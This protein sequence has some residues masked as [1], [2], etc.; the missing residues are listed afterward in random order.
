MLQLKAWNLSLSR[1]QMV[2]IACWNMVVWDVVLAIQ[3]F[4]IDERIRLHLNSNLVVL[5]QSSN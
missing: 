5:I 4:F 1:V 2:P 3:S